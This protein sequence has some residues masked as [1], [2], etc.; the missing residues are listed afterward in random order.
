MR[1]GS[2]FIF[3]SVEV[4]YYHLQ[5]NNSEQK[6]KNKKTTIN[7]KND[8]NKRFHYALT[9]ASNH[10]DIEKKPKPSTNIKN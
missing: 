6:G 7:P 10:Q 1:R 9:V 3:D 2:N 4:L 8:D 5:K